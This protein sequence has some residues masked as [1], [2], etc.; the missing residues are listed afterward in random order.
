MRFFREALVAAMLLGCGDESSGPAVP[1]VEG[2]E[3]GA[4]QSSSGGIGEAKA[5]DDDDKGH[6]GQTRGFFTPG[7]GGGT[8]VGT[9]FTEISKLSLPPGEYIANASAV[10]SFSGSQELHLVDCV[11]TIGERIKGE[12]ARGAFAASVSGGF[13]TLPLTLGVTISTTS[14]LVVACRSDVGDVV[15]SQ[16]SPI[17]AIRVNRL[18]VQP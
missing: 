16:S 6:K 3:S 1:Q 2:S 13:V 11:F 15:F 7:P 8:F 4:L 17:T 18:T 5:K 14:D 9:A 12:Q 10:L